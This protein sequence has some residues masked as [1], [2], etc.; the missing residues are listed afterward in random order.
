MLSWSSW[1]QPVIIFLVKVFLSFQG[2]RKK[3]FSLFCARLTINFP[4]SPVSAL[5]KTSYTCPAVNWRH[6]RELTISRETT[7][8]SEILG[9]FK[10]GGLWKKKNRTCGHSYTKSYFWWPLMCLAQ[11]GIYDGKYKSLDR[12]QRNFS[13]RFSFYRRGKRIIL[14]FTASARTGSHFLE[15]YL[16][17]R[18]I[19]Q[20]IGLSFVGR[21]FFLVMLYLALEKYIFI[22]SIYWPFL[23]LLL[24]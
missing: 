14:K 13:I 16:H 22:I 4:T 17:D 10:G 9:I 15:T 5:N 21:Y 24:M 7:T 1:F 23:T 11:Y 12:C 18:S 3:R 2:S 6:Q 19:T 20:I 8:A